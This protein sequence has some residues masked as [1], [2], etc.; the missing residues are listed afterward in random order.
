M[1]N[2]F[3]HCYWEEAMSIYSQV[4]NSSPSKPVDEKCRTSLDETKERV[5]DQ[6]T[7]FNVVSP[8]YGKH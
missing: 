5:I 1:E 7:G 2:Y 4:P 6:S 3:V 8:L